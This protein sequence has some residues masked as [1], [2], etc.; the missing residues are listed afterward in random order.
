M[1]VLIAEDDS[2]TATLVSGLLRGSGYE[3]SVVSDGSAALAN[4]RAD[5]PPAIALL[6]WMLPGLDGPDICK[7][8]RGD[9]RTVPTYLILCTARD[10]REDVVRGL[11]AGADDYLVKPFDPEE[12]RARVK[13]GMRIVT[14]EQSL[15]AHVK[16]LQDALASVKKLSGLLP[17][18]GYCKSI[19]D[20]DTYWH[21]VEEYVTEHSEARFSHGICPDCLKKVL[22]E[23][24]GVEA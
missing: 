18:C 4:L 21:R 20:D 7:A 16:E 14:L 22:R 2:A 15:A 9:A 1:R 5:D 11:E 24:A 12:L 6:D 10:S 23:E 8:I 19:R 13:A 17:I 3:V